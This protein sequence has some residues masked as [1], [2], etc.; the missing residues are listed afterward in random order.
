MPRGSAGIFLQR[1]FSNPYINH[2]CMA[3]AVAA[4]DSSFIGGLL[5]KTL[6]ESRIPSVSPGEAA[7]TGLSLKKLW[8]GVYQD[9]AA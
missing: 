2:C 8:P 4:K 7:I 5:G 1:A 6:G 3:C 9:K